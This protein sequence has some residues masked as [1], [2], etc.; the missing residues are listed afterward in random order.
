MI[1]TLRYTRVWSH[2]LSLYVLAWQLPRGV[3]SC[4]PADRSVLSSFSDSLD[5]GIAVWPGGVVNSSSDCCRWPGVRCRRLSAASESELRVVHLDLAGRG[6]AGSLRVQGGGSL[7]RLDKLSFLN[8][9]R[10]SLHGPI[11]P[12]L[13]LR[14]PR[15]RVLDL[16]HNF[17]S[18]QLAD[19]AAPAPAGAFESGYPKSKLAHLDVSLNSLTGLHDGVCRGLPRLRSFSAESNLLAGTVPRSLSSCSG[20]EYLNMD[21]NSLH[22]ALGDLNFTRL[23]R[24]RALH[25]GWNQL[26]GRIP[27][28]LSSC[29]HLRVV[30]L[31]RNFL[32]G[33][34]PSAFRHLQ[35]LAFFNVGNNSIT[36]IA[37]ALRVLQ[38]CR[39]LAV[40]ILTMN[41]HGEEMP[42]GP[43]MIDAGAGGIRGFPRLQLLG[44]AACALRGA[45]PQWLRASARLSVLDHLSWNRLT[46]AVLY[47]IDLSNELTGDIPLSITRMKS[48]VAADDMSASQA[49]LSDYGVRLYNWHVDCGELWY[50]GNIPASLDLS[51]NSLAGTIPPEIGDLREL[52]ILNLS[53]NA[54]SG[55]IPATLASL[56]SLQALELSHNELAGEIPASLA[57]LTFLSSFDVSHNR[58]RGVIPNLSQ[59]STFPCSSFAGNPGLHGEYC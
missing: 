4:T 8:L 25:L 18:G 1:F 11:P 35:S 22:G 20:L 51:Q 50:D 2:L 14:M 6:L 44:M 32:S 56:A 58:L 36:G 10:N 39:A 28:S 27:E 7:A 53:W 52:N 42:G 13:L 59:F 55:P 49:S 26:R 43:G 45:V 54:L 57:G 21:N 3:F 34:V 31:R 40:K 15:L 30:N 37:H 41:F 19:M 24:L 33:P 5:A 17:F 12:E 38:E 29:R 46:G 23:S 47:R 16:S 9:S 48:L